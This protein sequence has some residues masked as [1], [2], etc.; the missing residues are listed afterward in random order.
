MDVNPP[1][2]TSN[3]RRYRTL[4]RWTTSGRTPLNYQFPGRH[5]KAFQH[6]PPIRLAHN[7]DHLTTCTEPHLTTTRKTDDIQVPLTTL[8]QVR[9]VSYNSLRLGCRQQRTKRGRATLLHRAVDVP[10]MSACRHRDRNLLWS[11]D[12]RPRKLQRCRDGRPHC[13]TRRRHLSL[14][15]WKVSR[16]CTARKN[17]DHVG[18]RRLLLIVKCPHHSPTNRDGRARAVLGAM[19]Q[20]PAFSR[21]PYRRRRL[22][23]RSRG[24]GARWTLMRNQLPAQ[25]ALRLPRLELV[26]TP[27][28]MIL[29][30]LRVPWTGKHS[31]LEC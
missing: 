2:P 18:V 7:Q 25:S 22:G 6:V 5:T 14:L 12:L 1:L 21:M 10:P 19:E 26:A 8:N 9:P 30:T 20:N 24:A 27:T 28:R 17:G 23:F 4:V 13:T 11:K 16:A 31:L 3:Q 15:L 29:P